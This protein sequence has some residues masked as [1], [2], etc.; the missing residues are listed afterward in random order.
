MKKV[1]LQFSVKALETEHTGFLE[2]TYLYVM[3]D[4]DSRYKVGVILPELS[5]NAVA[6]ALKMLLTKLPARIKRRL[7]SI[8][9]SGKPEFARLPK[10][11]PEACTEL[12]LPQARCKILDKGNINRLAVLSFKADDNEFFWRISKAKDLAELNEWYDE[13]MDEYNVF[14]P[15]H[16]LKGYTPTEALA[17]ED[18]T[19]PLDWP[20][21]RKAFFENKRVGRGWNG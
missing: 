12:E 19:H 9:V 16:G 8:S 14:R 3:I 17:F 4:T 10:V 6:E 13:W 20:L 11:L 21:D 18:R 1:D 7:G 15:H 2:T 5:C